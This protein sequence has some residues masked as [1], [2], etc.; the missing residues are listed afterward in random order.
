MSTSSP[1]PLIESSQTYADELTRQE[2]ARLNCSPQLQVAG[3]KHW[4]DYKPVLDIQDEESLD[5][6]RTAWDRLGDLYDKGLVPVPAV[7]TSQ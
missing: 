4:F 6:E 2:A 3:L 7:A 5:D 1:T